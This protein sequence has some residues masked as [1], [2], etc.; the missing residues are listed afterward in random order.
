MTPALHPEGHGWRCASICA[1]RRPACARASTR[2]PRW[3][4]IRSGHL[5]LLVGRERDRLKILYWDADGFA[6]WCKRPEE[7]TFRLPAAKNTGASVELKARALAR[8]L[9]G[10]DLTSIRRR[11][12]CALRS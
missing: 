4:T 9:A 2:W 10:S 12:R 8:L 11:H 5:F 3:G 6:I 1:R 7:G